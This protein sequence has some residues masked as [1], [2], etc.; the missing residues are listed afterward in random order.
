MVRPLPQSSRELLVRSN[1]GYEGAQ[2]KVCCPPQRTTTPTPQPVSPLTS[3]IMNPVTQ[4]PRPNNQQEYR[5]PPP[6]VTRH[7]NL[8]MLPTNCGPLEDDRI[9]GGNKT[10]VFD[11]PWMALLAY[12]TARGMSFRCGGTIINERYILT[13]AHCITNLRGLTLAGVRVGEHDIRNETDCEGEADALDCA[14]PPQDF[15][16]EEILPHPSYSP[17][18]L[19][20]DIGLLRLSAPIDFNSENSKPVCLPSSEALRNMRLEGTTIVV[21]GWGATETGTSS[22]ELLRVNLPVLTNTR[23]GEIHNRSVAAGIGFKQVCAGGIQG[24]D[25]CGGDSGG[26]LMSPGEVGGVQRFVQHGIV[27]FGPKR[28]GTANLP[29]VYTRVAYYMDWLLDQLKP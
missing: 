17:V 1:C 7:P 8:S 2:P 4:A 6:D 28:C 27:S 23:C 26:P 15:T 22:P 21:T 5:E 10:G 11:F 18:R 25:S 29:G 14:P 13:A 3:R 16:I 20:D 9:L 24:V 12:N 19:Q